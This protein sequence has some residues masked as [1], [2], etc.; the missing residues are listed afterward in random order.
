M[1][2]ILQQSSG[3]EPLQHFNSHKEQYHVSAGVRFK[4]CFLQVS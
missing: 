1:G 2:E 3:I 4:F